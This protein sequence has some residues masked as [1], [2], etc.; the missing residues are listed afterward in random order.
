MSHIVLVHGAWQGA[1]CWER[2]GPLLRQAGHVVTAESLTGCGEH[3]AELSPSVTLAS[4]HRSR[5]DA[6][7]PTCSRRHCDIATH[8]VDS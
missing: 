7:S 3:S 2:V 5:H 8:E 6:R 4:R 1:W